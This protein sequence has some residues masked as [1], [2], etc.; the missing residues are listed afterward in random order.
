MIL[1]HDLGTTGD[2]ATLVGHDG[3]LIDSVTVPYGVDFGPGGKAEQ[4]TE[5]W[6]GALRTATRALLERAGADRTSV[7]VV[8]FSGQMM[9]AV[10][11]DRDNLPVRPAIIW[12]D[13]RSA[14]Q[15]HRIIEAVGMARGY[16]IT[17]HRL[18]P[19]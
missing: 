11:V 19:T 18:N 6:W 8:T 10:L 15:T 12:A 14:Q 5:D 2:K 1:S 13:T 4:D 7:D 17:G 9:G 3:A 16:Q